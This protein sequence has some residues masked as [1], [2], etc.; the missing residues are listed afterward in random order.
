MQITEAT[1]YLLSAF[2]VAIAFI[3]LVS[4][5]E[6]AKKLSKKLRWA[7]VLL[8]AS[9]PSLAIL[10]SHLFNIQG[11]RNMLDSNFGAIIFPLHIPSFILTVLIDR[12]I[13]AYMNNR[14]ALYSSDETVFFT[15]LPLVIALF[16]G[17]VINFLIN[18]FV[19]KHR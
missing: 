9:I 14:T 19:K 17:I 12:Q 4:A 8:W 15:W 7:L 10:L 18:W 11:P 6:L 13:F 3:A 1:F 2:L 5:L 16:C